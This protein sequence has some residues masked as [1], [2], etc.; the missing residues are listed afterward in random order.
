MLVDGVLALALLAFGVAN[1]IRGP[2]N[3]AGVLVSVPLVIAIVVPVVFRRRHPVGAF[4]VA[5]VAGAI[6]LLINFRASG[7]DV[8]I[9]ILLYTLAA[10]RP[11]NISLPGLVVVLGGV[12]AA[13]ARWF[14][15]RLDTAET[16]F[17]ASL[18]M[19]APSVIAWVLGDSMRYRR[20][21]YRGLE[22]RT[23]Q[24]ERE[25]DAQAQVA[26]A[27]ER[28]R[29]ARELHDVV[30]HNV[31]VMVVQA[32]GAGY[33]L[34]AEP[35]RARQA[36]SDISRTGRQALAEM[37]RLLGVLRGSGERTGPGGGHTGINGTRSGGARSGTGGAGASVT[38]HPGGLA[39]PA[40]AA[41]QAGLAP[42]PGTAQLGDLL[43]QT[44][45][46]GLEVSMTVTGTQRPLLAGID[47]A[48]YR[49]V[50]E[51]LTNV[52]KHAGPFA[53]A[54]VVLRYGRD[55][56]CLEITDDGRG[57]AAHSDGAGHGLTGMRERV[58][59]YGG[60]LRAR[61]RPGGGFQVTAR[62]PVAPQSPDAPGALT[63]GAAGD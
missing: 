22:E 3:R 21:Y 27:A 45:S 25:R 4:G 17:A 30:A 9:L 54:A 14:P 33:A 58:E 37:R 61:A 53:R 24:L 2:G 28:A 18:S 50:Q 51:A 35:E 52:R 56:L 59:M 1:G 55:E 43:E 46:A 19:V 12:A 15:S 63:A 16:F 62:I 60:T 44:R 57:A 26:A 47:L 32:D 39:S 8:A 34:D 5:I 48:A 41:E 13:V 49:V 11:R 42:L 23:A 10:Y 6:E 20:A 40:M 38:R 7:A 31:S 36:L 29:I